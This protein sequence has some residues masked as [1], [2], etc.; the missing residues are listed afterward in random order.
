MTSYGNRT[1]MTFTPSRAINNMS[2]LPKS[3]S[4]KNYTDQLMV[5]DSQS[6]FSKTNLNF[7]KVSPI[8]FN[9]VKNT[10]DLNR[11]IHNQTLIKP[12]I[13]LQFE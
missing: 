10:T 9:K 12:Q 2:P 4:P 11:L 13:R 6:L 1:Q 8:N 3:R 7:S 5:E